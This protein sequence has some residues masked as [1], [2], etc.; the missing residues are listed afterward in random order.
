[1]EYADVKQWAIQL[2]DGS[3]LVMGYDP[4]NKYG[5]PGKKLEFIER[6]PARPL[7]P[8]MPLE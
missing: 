6:G 8:R 7:D 3:L 2:E 1:L 4:S 5:Q